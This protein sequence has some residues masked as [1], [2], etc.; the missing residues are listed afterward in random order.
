VSS[1]FIE[2]FDNAR[3][4][5]ESLFLVGAPDR[6]A[7][8]LGSHPGEERGERRHRKA[9]SPLGPGLCSPA[10]DEVSSGGICMVAQTLSV[11]DTTT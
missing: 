10:G 7:A 6:G 4:R 9:G 2:L 8:C 1:Q 3:G 11:R 5:V